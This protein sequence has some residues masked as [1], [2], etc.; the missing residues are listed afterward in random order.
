M[1]QDA[2]DGQLDN[3]DFSYQAC[4]VFKPTS[5]LELDIDDRPKKRRKTATVEDSSPAPRS[6]PRLCAGAELEEYARSREEAFREAWRVA[7]SRIE[8]GA[9]SI[10]EAA[11]EKIVQCVHEGNNPAERVR[12]AV[13]VSGSDTSALGQCIRRL[14]QS[15]DA[16]LVVELQASHAPTLQTALRTLIRNAIETHSNIGEYNAFVATQKRQIPMIF[17]LE[18]LQRYTAKKGLHKV[19]VAMPDAETFDL[20]VFSELITNLASWKDRIH[21]VLLLGLATTVH[22]FESR[23]AKST[24]RLLDAEVFSLK[25]EGDSFYDI[26]SAVQQP[27]SSSI[28]PRIQGT[29]PQLYVGPSVVSALNDLSQDQSLTMHT[30]TAAV[31]YAHMTH[32]FANPLS[33]LLRPTAIDVSAP[34]LTLCEAIRNTASFQVHCSSI[35]DG[36]LPNTNPSIVRKLL[37]DDRELLQYSIEQLHETSRHYQQKV[38][39]LHTLATVASHLSTGS[40]ATSPFTHYHQLTQALHR[41]QVVGSD[42]YQL[43]LD[44]LPPL[45]GPSLTALLTKLS[46]NLTSS[47]PINTPFNLLGHIDHLINTILAPPS[48]SPPPYLNEALL[49]TSRGPLVSAFNP[50]PR[51]ALERALSSP[52]DYLGCDCCTDTTT[53]N[54][55]AAAANAEKEPATVLYGLLAEAGREVNVFDLWSTFRDRMTLGSETDDPTGS[56]RGQGQGAKGQKGKVSTG[57]TTTTKKGK[58]AGEADSG[59]GKGKDKSNTTAAAA[60]SNSRTRAPNPNGHDATED[61]NNDNDSAPDA[62]PERQAL[63]LFYR[64]LAELRHLGLVKSTSDRRLNKGV[65]VVSRTTWHGL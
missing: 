44:A 16:D 43:I 64:A 26:F 13:V 8:N 47:E 34:N 20:N 53:N 25:S 40:S 46:P 41:G 2:D 11:V 54:K 9:G 33:V 61:S 5:T 60:K 39:A 22:L 19:V 29:A 14:R 36:R 12:T 6:W 10:D 31:K 35:L 3:D 45:P 63:T 65:E 17:D 56:G 52:S 50:R 57:K 32:F 28:D 4:Y 27:A 15:D 37:D 23:L 7:E 62:D 21:F 30:F 24:A 49:I 51:F 38:A 18:L 42:S 59:K 1:G 48:S 55:G 58:A